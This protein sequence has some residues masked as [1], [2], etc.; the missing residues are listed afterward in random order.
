MSKQRNTFQYQISQIS[1]L[2]DTVDD[3]P[4]YDEYITLHNAQVIGVAELDTNR[5]CLNCKARVKPQMPPL[6][7]C[8]C[9]DCLMIQLF[10][11]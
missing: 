7:K 8:S 2:E 5:A 4:K 1:D 9:D 6:G 11:L 3:L 10:E